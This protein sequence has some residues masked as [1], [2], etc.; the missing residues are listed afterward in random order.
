MT[1]SPAISVA[2]VE[3]DAG[4]RQRLANVLKQAPG[5]TCAGSFATA[6]E[7][8]QAI[9]QLRPQVVFMDINLPDHNGVWAVQQLSPLLP[10][11]QIV[12]LTVHDDTDTI[13][14]SLAAGAS[15]YLLKP[16]QSAEFIDAVRNV[17]SGGVP[18][19]SNIARKIIHSFAQPAPAAASTEMESLTDRE[20]EVLDHLAK[21]YLYKEVADR[22][23]ISYRT[24]HTHIE[25]IYEKLHVRSRTQAVAR[26]FDHGR[27]EAAR[28]ARPLLPAKG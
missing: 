1:N 3:D 24:V 11:T 22:L 28:P 19:A 21:G 10:R 13:F 9:P 26:F 4:V 15:G 27:G 25:H 20:R 18:M 5:I 14:Q 2:L 16:V 23:N 6:E 7:A 12:M 8:V 17:S